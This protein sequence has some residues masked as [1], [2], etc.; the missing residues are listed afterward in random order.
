[1][2]LLFYQTG[3]KLL[4]TSLKTLA[5]LGHKKA[6]KSVLGKKNWIK[7]LSKFNNQKKTIWIHA[8]S[9]GEAIMAIPLIRRILELKNTQLIMSFFSPSGYE[10]FTFKDTNFIKIYL[11]FD[12]KTNSKQIVELINPKILIFVKYDLWLNLINKCQ[13]KNIPTLVF[14]SKFR[15][16]Q[17]YFKIY[18]RSAQ[19]I[20]KSINCILT[21]DHLSKK[22]LKEN[23][24]E[25]VKHSGDT[26]YDQVSENIPT[27]KLIKKYP[28]IIL[29]SSWKD[30]ELIAAQNIREINNVSWIIAPHD[31]DQKKVLKIKEIFGKD[32][33]LFSEL[34]VEKPLP[35][36]L[37]IDKIG[38]L[39]ELYFYSDIAFIGGGFSGKLHNIL[40]AAS[41]GNFILFGP[42]IKN[43]PEANL[44]LKE[45]V[46]Q[47][48]KDKESFKKII[49]E[50][51]SNP[52]ELKRKQ[53]RAIELIKENR[54]ATNKV[55]NEIEKLI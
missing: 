51:I 40:E 33:V 21:V 52:K 32:S 19:N 45:E 23:G 55:W 49:L 30:E 38:V 43:Y 13:K 6:K 46:S 54:G 35:K 2:S 39:A 53:K 26:R 8:A 27:L 28:C 22:V 44:M 50:L 11:P 37:I 18:G 31:I 41:K 1:M 14:S 16:D 24:F 42:K 5:F 47:V 25:N 3:I 34:D 20:L 15:A 36:I 9:H 7:D 29:G 48:V 12:S 4:S 17:W 10:N